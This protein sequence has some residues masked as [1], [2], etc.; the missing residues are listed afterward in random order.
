[1]FQLAIFLLLL[2]LVPLLLVPF[3]LKAPTCRF[4]PKHCNSN[5]GLRC[6]HKLDILSDS[7]H[8]AAMAPTVALVLMPL[9]AYASQLARTL[10]FPSLP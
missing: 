5:A 9:P 4:Y 10:A 2:L 6:M 8:A 1:M 7:A 3:F